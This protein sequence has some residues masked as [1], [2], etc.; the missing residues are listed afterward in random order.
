MVNLHG[1][2]FALRAFLL[3]HNEDLEP[4]VDLAKLEVGDKVPTNSFTSYAALGKL[5][6]AFN[7]V[8]RSK[9]CSCCLDRAV[10]DLRDMIAHGL[11]AG[12][13]PNPPFALL[14]FG[15]ERGGQVP[16]EHKVTLDHA[17]LSSKIHFVYEQIRKVQ[18]ASQDLG[19]NI[20]EQS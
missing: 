12:R 7:N 15:K 10:V 6:D 19:Q 11:V 5:V 13:V 8:V 2:E 9:C 4:E 1:L 3:K 17:W 20:M 18:A 16:L 14:K